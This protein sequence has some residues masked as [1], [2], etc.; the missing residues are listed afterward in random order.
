[1]IKVKDSEVHFSGD[2]PRL[3]IDLVLLLHSF[4][5][6]VEEDMSRADAEKMLALAGKLAVLD[7]KGLDEKFEEIVEE[8]KSAT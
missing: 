3:F 2:L 8:F 4:I 7:E 6:L 5:G 1:M